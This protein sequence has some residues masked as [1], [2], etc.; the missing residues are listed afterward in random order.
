MSG[1]L[2]LI[3]LDFNAQKKRGPDIDSIL[4]ML[5]CFNLPERLNYSGGRG[6]F[7]DQ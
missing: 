4:T 6:L 1:G 2:K 7:F 5:L 3:Q